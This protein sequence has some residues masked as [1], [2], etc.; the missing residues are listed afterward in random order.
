MAEEKKVTKTAAKSTAKKTV[1]AKS[2]A[3]TKKIE[4]FRVSYYQR[5]CERCSTQTLTTHPGRD[6]LMKSPHRFRKS[7]DSI[8]LKFFG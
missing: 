5:S 4:N 6:Y 2:T 8:D 1:A 3:T 7:M